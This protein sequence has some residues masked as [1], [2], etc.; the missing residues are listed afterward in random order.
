VD[1]GNTNDGRLTAPGG[2]Q[3]GA[4]RPRFATAVVALL[5]ACAIGGG[6]AEAAVYKWVDDKGVTHYTDKM[7]P[8][9]VN[10][11]NVE[12]NK[13]GVA[14]R[15]TEPAVTPEQRKAIEAE[16]ERKREAARQQAEQARRD[17][18]LL[19]SYT[20]EG[21]IDLAR[22]RSLRTVETALRSA[23]AYSAQL[24]K[25]RAELAASKAA[26]AG[27][28]VPAALER[29][30]AGADAELARQ[31]EFVAR[32]EQELVT[33]AARYDAD[34]ARWQALKGGSAMTAPPPAAGSAAAPAAARA[35][36]AKK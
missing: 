34:K 6:V 11:G 7:P 27:K 2:M 14:I 18:A 25:H 33:I 30:L 1:L 10:K 13:Q 36:T 31:T 4:S 17:R 29:D 23:Q 32:K 20:S 3:R 28:P 15:K 12:L 22:T 21:D 19:D 9:A 8:D 24:G 5:I 16:A 35:G 26:L